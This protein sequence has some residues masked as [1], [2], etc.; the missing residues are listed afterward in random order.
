M[1][2]PFGYSSNVQLPTKDIVGGYILPESDIYDATIKQVYIKKTDS[3][4]VGFHISAAVKDVERKFVLYPAIAKKDA[5]GVPLRNPDNSIQVTNTRVQRDGTEVYLDAFLIAD[6]MS[7]ILFGKPLSQMPL[8]PI[9]IEEKDKQTKQP[10]QVQV[11]AYKDFSGKDVKLVLQRSVKNKQAKN[12]KTGKWESTNEK[13]QEIELVKILRKDDM[14]TINEID[15]GATA[16]AY[17][18]EW[19][20]TWKGKDKNNYKPV[21][22]FAANSGTSSAQASE[23][24]NPFG[25]V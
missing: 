20:K 5:N 3:G 17:A 19:L 18:E 14:L 10:V 11:M 4:A 6:S 16:A 22:G 21:A 2:N 25:N 7:R 1:T 24:D 9:F 13:T 23:A 8:E 12:E 15:A